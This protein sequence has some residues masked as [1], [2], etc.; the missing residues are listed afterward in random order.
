MWLQAF[1]K[2]NYALEVLGLREDG[3]HEIRTVM[4]SISLA[5]EIELDLASHGFDLAVEPA[6][7]DVGSPEG[8]TVF[9]AWRALREATG[10]ELP[11]RVRLHKRIPAGAGLAGGSAD[12]A[13]IL[14]GLNEL[15]G[16]GLSEKELRGVGARVGADVPFCVVGGTVLG[17][18]IGDALTVLPAAPD[19]HLLVARP[20]KAASTAEVYRRH[21]EHPAGCPPSVEPALAALRAGD[22]AA[23]ARAAGNDLASITHALVPEV[24]ALEKEMLKAGASGAAMTGSGTAVFGLFEREEEARRAA[25]RL[26]TASVGVYEP[27]LRGVEIS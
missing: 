2:V 11:A 26:R 5:D 6:G 16:L 17:E 7:V 19:H 12:A 23:F 1:A 14:V 27:T 3:Y 20:G 15:Y 9:R 24:A 25:T 22:L 13:A 21:D 18:G 10:E 8:N 4:Q